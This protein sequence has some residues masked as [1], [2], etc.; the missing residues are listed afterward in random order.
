MRSVHDWEY[1]WDL[2][3]SQGKKC[4][5]SGIDLVIEKSICRKRGQ[6]NITAS[7]DRIDSSLGYVEGNL[8]WIHKDINY[9][10]QDLDEEYFKKLCKE[11]TDYGQGN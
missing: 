3:L 6:S 8:Q 2:F 11:I 7:L 5:L 9:M 1:C 4:S 10:K